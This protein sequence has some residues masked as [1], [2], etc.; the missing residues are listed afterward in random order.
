MHAL[1]NNVNRSTTVSKQGSMHELT[2][3]TP[4]L[5]AVHGRNCLAYV[6]SRSAGFRQV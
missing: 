4:H 6:N 3:V 1:S 5:G 2:E